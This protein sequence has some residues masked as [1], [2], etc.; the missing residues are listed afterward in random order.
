MKKIDDM[1]ERELKELES[2]R[3][4]YISDWEKVH[5]EKKLKNEILRILS[6]EI[7]S[8]LSKDDENIIYQRKKTSIKSISK[9]RTIKKCS[10]K[11]KK[12]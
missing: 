12:K 5:A 9:R 10:C 6:Q 4:K 11:N 1:T 7:S 8:P 3:I 2:Q